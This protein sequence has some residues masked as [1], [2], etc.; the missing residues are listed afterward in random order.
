MGSTPVAL[1]G[2]SPCCSYGDGDVPVVVTVGVVLGVGVAVTVVVGVGV[3][4]GVG[5]CVMAGV[6]VGIGSVLENLGVAVWVNVGTCDGCDD[7]GV[8][9]CWSGGFV[10]PV[11]CSMY[12]G[13]GPCG[14]GCSLPD[15]LPTVADFAGSGLPTGWSSIALPAPMNM[16]PVA[17]IASTE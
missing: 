14:A 17:M 3:G 13:S 8:N 11:Y 1:L 16:T 2:N 5:V 4:V 6:P 15:G 7:G 12:D 9:E 10:G